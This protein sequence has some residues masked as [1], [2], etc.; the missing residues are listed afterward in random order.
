MNFEPFATSIPRITP[1]RRYAD[2]FP[3]SGFFC[4]E[5]SDQD[6]GRMIAQSD[7]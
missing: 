1:I 6:R 5:E 2:T 3:L 4:E 7:L